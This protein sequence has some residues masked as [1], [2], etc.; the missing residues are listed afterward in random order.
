MGRGKLGKKIRLSG[1][2]WIAAAELPDY[3]CWSLTAMALRK[4]SCAPTGG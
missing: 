3:I 2:Y 4:A 1:L